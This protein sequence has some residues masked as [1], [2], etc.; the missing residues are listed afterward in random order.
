MEACAEGRTLTVASG[1][2]TVAIQDVLVGDVWICGGQSNMGRPVT[3][4]QIKSADLPLIRLLGSD[5]NTP[6]SEGVDDTVGWL[7]C[8]PESIA[9]AGSGTAEKRRPF[10]EVAFVFGRYLQKDLKI[11]ISLF[12]MNCGGSTAKAW[13]PTEGVAATL[14]AGQPS[15][16]LTRTPGVLYEVRMRGTVPM[17]VRGVMWYQGED[18]G[19]SNK[20]AEDFTAMIA[21]WRRLYRD[22]DLPF[23][24][25]QIAQTTYAGG[26]LRVWKA[27]QHL[28]NTVL[29]TGMAVSNDIYDGTRSCA[30]RCR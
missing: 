8:S 2:Q 14:T 10:S 17:T 19:R 13:T 15:A 9:T 27:R 29:H 11:P 12:Q 3:G 5:G 26:M 20:Y 30:G 1:A 16:R 21:A 6:R 25:A 24:F 22:P 7:V 18:D 23:Y 28:M 4:D